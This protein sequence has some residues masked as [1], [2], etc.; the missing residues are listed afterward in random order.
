M[1]ADRE[2]DRYHAIADLFGAMESAGGIDELADLSARV[3]RAVLTAASTSI[4][5]Y[6]AEAGQVRTLVNV[7]E[8][9]P[10]EHRR[11]VD[12]RY[13]VT[14]FPNLLQVAEQQQPW[15][16]HLADRQADTAEL[17]LLRMLGK[18]ASL[19]CPIVL[20]A[21]VWGELYATR[22][23]DAPPFTATDRAVARMIA[24][25]VALCVGRLVGRDELRELV[26]VDALTGLGN[27]RMLDETLQRLSEQQAPTTVALWDVDGLKRVN[28]R[29]GHLAGD[30]LLR[31]VGLLL[32]E[33]AGRLPG[34]VA[35]RLGGDEFCLVAP[36]HDGTQVADLLADLVGRASALV[37]GAGVSSGVASCDALRAEPDVKALLR[38]ADVALYRAKAAGGRRQVHDTA[39]PVESLGAPSVTRLVG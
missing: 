13:A 32:S 23:G 4:S 3:A 28:D 15:S 6:D 12:E 21:R 31:Q 14:D 19:G 27:R 18:S 24:Q 35:N 29:D 37:A 5:R 1:E 9:G 17:D 22:A 36:G 38:R 30:R 8:L 7:G 10:G 16:V 26:Y 2:A 11:P 25:A 34:S 33:A 39:L 20:G